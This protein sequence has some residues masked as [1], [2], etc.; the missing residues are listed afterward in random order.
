MTIDQPV[1]GTRDC[2]RCSLLAHAQHIQPHIFPISR[3]L[4]VNFHFRKKNPGP[5][6]N[7]YLT[8]TYECE[9]GFEM[10]NPGN[11]KMFCS[12]RRWVA[13]KPRC[14]R[15]K[16]KTQYLFWILT[17]KNCN[18]SGLSNFDGQESNAGILETS[19]VLTASWYLKELED[20]RN[21]DIALKPHF[22]VKTCD[23]FRL[24]TL[25][26]DDFQPMSSSPRSSIV[27]NAGMAVEI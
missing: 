6:Q 13:T 25:A 23:R 16:G 15:L 18:I 10:R 4:H 9:D 19:F 27:P 12:G 24:K 3:Y 22:E 26:D 7:R 1:V 5:L 8:A 20:L 17:P 21:D 11:D 2:G 14:I